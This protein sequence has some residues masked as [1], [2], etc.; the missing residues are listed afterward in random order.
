MAPEIGG[1]RVPAERKRREQSQQGLARRSVAPGEGAGRLEGEPRSAQGYAFLAIH[2]HVDAG[3]LE[4][5][6]QHHLFV[7]SWCSHL[8][9]KSLFR[10]FPPKLDEC[11]TNLLNTRGRFEANS[12][13]S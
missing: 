4:R 7:L 6:D 5:E 13:P 10:L 12:P 3:V 9:S 2:T 11:G 1:G 8:R